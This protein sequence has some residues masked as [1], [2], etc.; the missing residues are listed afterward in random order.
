MEEGRPDLRRLV[1]IK[2]TLQCCSMCDFIIHIWL[3][4]SLLVAQFFQLLLIDSN[5][6]QP[7]HC[8]LAQLVVG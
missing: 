8:V 1:N 7:G 6:V 3:M 4:V 5:W 2:A